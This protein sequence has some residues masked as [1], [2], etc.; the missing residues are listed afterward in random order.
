MAKIVGSLPF[1]ISID[2]VK[3]VGWET[4]VVGA[5]AACAYLTST[6]IPSLQTDSDLFKLTLLTAAVGM[7]KGI[8][9]WLSN[10]VRSE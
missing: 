8:S 4:F 6:V 9:A 1:S 5:I 10:T 2:D 7:V 3:K